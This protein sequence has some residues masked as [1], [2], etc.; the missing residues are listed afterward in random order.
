MNYFKHA[1]NIKQEATT[2]SQMYLTDAK[3]SHISLNIVF[4]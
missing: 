1:E 4:L 3:I 2:Y